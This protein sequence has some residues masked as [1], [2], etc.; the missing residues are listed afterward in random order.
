MQPT[1]QYSAVK[2]GI[3]AAVTD[4]RYRVFGGAQFDYG[5]QKKTGICQKAW[6]PG[7]AATSTFPYEEQVSD[8]CAVRG[9]PPRILCR[10]DAC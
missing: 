4:R 6:S 5:L 3:P 7:A 1:T 2:W 9:E 8:V 10:A